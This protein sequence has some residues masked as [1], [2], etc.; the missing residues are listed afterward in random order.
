MW[1]TLPRRWRAGGRGRGPPES[2][3]DSSDSGP[4]PRLPSPTPARDGLHQVD[5]LVHLHHGL[6]EGRVLRRVHP[7]LLVLEELRKRLPVVVTVRHPRGPTQKK[8]HESPAETPRPCPSRAPEDGNRGLTGPVQGSRRLDV[9]LIP[10]LR[11]ALRPV[12]VHLLPCEGSL[13]RP[14]VGPGPRSRPVPVLPPR[15]DRDTVWARD[16]RGA[17]PTCIEQMGFVDP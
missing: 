8:G 13:R 14:L 6:E 1:V 9:G 4:S 10:L 11:V 16:R 3:P 17:P 7:V 2:V 12:L 15:P 5:Q